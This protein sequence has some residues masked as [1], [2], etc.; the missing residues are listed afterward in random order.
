MSEAEIIYETYNIAHEISAGR[1]KA[2]A[3]HGQNSI[4]AVPGSEYG[5]WLAILGEEFG[6]ACS[7]LTYD[8]DSDDLRAELIDVATVTV[9]WIAA[10]DREFRDE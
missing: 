8:K 3:K 1:S 4:E 9:A 10:L 6:E 5:Q 7:A 2:H